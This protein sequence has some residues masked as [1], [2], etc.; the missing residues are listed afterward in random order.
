MAFSTP[1]AG[2]SSA[3][4]AVTLVVKQVSSF[5]ALANGSTNTAISLNWTQG[6]GASLSVAITGT[7]NNQ[8]ITFAVSFATTGSLASAMSVNEAGNV[9]Y[10][11]GSAVSLVTISQS[12]LL[13][14]AANS[15]LTGS[16]IVT[17]TINGTTA[18]ATTFSVSITVN[19]T[20]A[21][22]TAIWPP[23]LPV[24]STGAATAVVSG[25]GF[26]AGTTVKASTDGVNFTAA[27]V[28]TAMLNANNIAVQLAATWLGSAQVL[29]IEAYNGANT[30]STTTVG[31]VTTPIVQSVTNSAS[32][33]ENTSLQIAPYEMISI[34]GANF[35][36]SGGAV[37]TNSPSA[38]VY[39]VYPTEVANSAGKEVEVQSA[40]TALA[41]QCSVNPRFSL[42]PAPRSMLSFR[43]R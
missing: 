40:P 2:V 35:E 38:D 16:I 36:P 24:M 34:F 18:A 13:G 29:T 37:E 12:V 9:A 1:A 31:V 21:T 7:S 11:W 20:P 3:T 6:S 26:V 10:S 14:A 32:F 5:T 4:V 28:T 19:P 30:P 15:V 33:A 22:I 43:R 23:E 17:P 8:P 27:G 39:E 41:T 42:C 25:T